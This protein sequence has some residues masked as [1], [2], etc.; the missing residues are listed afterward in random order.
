MGTCGGGVSTVPPSPLLPS[1]SLWA[2]GGV[3]AKSVKRPAIVVIVG[4]ARGSELRWWGGR[5]S[6]LSS[7]WS[8]RERRAQGR[9]VGVLPV[10]ATVVAAEGTRLGVGKCTLITVVIEGARGGSGQRQCA[11]RWCG[12]IVIVRSGRG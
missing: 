5:L 1:L 11:T 8:L 10:A 6:P 7:L 9:G 3:R 12:P 2:R 4:N